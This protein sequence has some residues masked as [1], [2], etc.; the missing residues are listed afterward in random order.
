MKTTLLLLFFTIPIIACEQPT[1]T[2]ELHEQTV[3]ITG[4]YEPEQYPTVVR[5][6]KPEL[7]ESSTEESKLTAK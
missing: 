3:E 1:I 4:S 6:T 2:V 5:S 7:A